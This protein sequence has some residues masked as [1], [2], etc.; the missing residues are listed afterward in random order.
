MPNISKYDRFSVNSAIYSNL[1]H[2]HDQWKNKV[3]IREKN[4]FHSVPP[5][6]RGRMFF[7]F[8]LNLKCILKK[9]SV[10]SFEPN[11]KRF[12]NRVV[13]LETTSRWKTSV[14][15]ATALEIDV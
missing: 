9:Q 6:S 15:N 2:Q 4:K 12:F 1:T 7:T 10:A 5:K 11:K 14:S 8:V 13:S 3:W